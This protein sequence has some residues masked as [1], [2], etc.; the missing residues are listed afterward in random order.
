[1]ATQTNKT[2][3]DEEVNETAAVDYYKQLV[4]VT[5]IKDNNN[6]KDDVTITYNGTNYQ[7]QRGVPVQIPMYIK[8][9]LEDGYRQQLAAD[10]Y[11]EKLS[12]DFEAKTTEIG[13]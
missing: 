12:H 6:Y 4:T 9:I 1:M 13:G 5:L 7:I 3:T 2:K 10:A 8:L 11:S